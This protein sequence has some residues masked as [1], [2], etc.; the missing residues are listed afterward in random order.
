[1]S[2]KPNPKEAKKTMHASARAAC[3]ESIEL[4]AFPG[5]IESRPEIPAKP[6]RDGR[7]PG[8]RSPEDEAF[9]ETLIRGL[10][11]GAPEAVEALFDRYHARIYNLALSIL[12]NDRDAEEA[13]QDVFVTVI[14][15][16][17]MFKGNSAFYSWIYRICVNACL[18]RLRKKRR[19]DAMFIE[20][21]MP[22]FDEVG[23]HAGPIDDWSKEV[24][25]KMMDKELGLV[26]RRLAAGLP[27][28]YRLVFHLSDIEEVPNPET[29]K[30]LGLSLAAVKS[31]LHRARLYMRERLTRYLR[32]GEIP[33]GETLS[34]DPGED[35]TEGPAE[36]VG[37][38]SALAAGRH[39]EPGRGKGR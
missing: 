33:A 36:P 30:I 38:A 32:D 14:R 21:F 3:T 7:R 25:R 1:L 4:F 26:I 15:K 35:P 6:Y 17:S 9:D 12:K 28:K 16:A 19:D 23:R 29:A 20:T 18:M 24:E 39:R 22:A 37:R 34:E 13:A 31:R 2:R 10:C 5:R 11:L 8:K 27:E